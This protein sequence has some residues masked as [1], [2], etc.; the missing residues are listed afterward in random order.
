MSK[1]LMAIYW[2]EQSNHAIAI[3]ESEPG[4]TPR[5]LAAWAAS[6]GLRAEV[7]RLA[8][9]HRPDVIGIAA[10]PEGMAGQHPYKS[11]IADH[12]PS[13]Q[14][15]K[16]LASIQ[17][18][19]ILERERF[20]SDNWATGLLALIGRSIGQPELIPA[21]QAIALALAN[22]AAVVTK[23]APMLSRVIG[24]NRQI[25]RKFRNARYY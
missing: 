13:V 2:D 21:G 22:R 1:R 16:R 7:V 18:Q 9:E 15:W 10:M 12:H 17:A 4:Q 23:S 8:A 19:A 5:L 14:S 25:T 3:L 11:A 6:Q 24:K 20:E